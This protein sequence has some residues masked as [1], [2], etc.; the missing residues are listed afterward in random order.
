VVDINGFFFNTDL[1]I[2]SFLLKVCGLLRMVFNL[3]FCFCLGCEENMVYGPIGKQMVLDKGSCH[4]W[5][6]DAA[7]W[8][9]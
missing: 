5:G 1:A 6:L 8:A 4:G 7:F 9:V 3:F 2:D